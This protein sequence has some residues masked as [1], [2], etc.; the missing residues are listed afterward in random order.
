MKA[1][2]IKRSAKAW[3]EETVG[4]MMA[5]EELPIDLELEDGQSFIE[6]YMGSSL[7]IFP[8]GKYYLPHACGNVSP[9]PR[10][11]GN[12]CDFCGH[13][14][15]REAYEDELMGEYLDEYAEKHGAFMFRGEGD[16]LDVFIGKII[17]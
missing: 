17:E 7:M 13:L 3:V 9:C 11:K 16:P 10:C 6:A 2:D 15:S 8:S 5:P 4:Y 14:G 1:R 12:G